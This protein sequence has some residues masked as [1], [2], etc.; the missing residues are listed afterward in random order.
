M[1]AL[2]QD[3]TIISTVYP[4][5]W[6]DLPDGSRCSPAEDGWSKDGYSLAAILP[7][8]EVPEGKRI[9]STS[10]EMVEGQPKYVHV[11]EDIPPPDRVSARQFKLQLLAA[12][13][14]DDVEAWVALQD[15]AVQIAFANSATFVR[16]DEMMQ[17]GFTALGFTEQQIDDFF[18]AAALL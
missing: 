13:L 12:G 9:V 5:G 16:T 2:I 3:D 8:D 4:G 17:S 6:F 18:T 11:L 15:Q 1:L 7:A 10:V 14:L